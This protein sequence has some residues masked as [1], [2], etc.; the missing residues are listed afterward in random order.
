MVQYHLHLETW[1]HWIY[2][3]YWHEMIEILEIEYWYTYWNNHV[4]RDFHS[5]QLSQVSNWIWY[6]T[7]QLIVVQL[8]IQNNISMFI[9][10]EYFNYLIS[11]TYSEVNW[12]K[13]PIESGIGP[14]N[15]LEPSS[16]Y[17]IIYQYLL[18]FEIWT[19]KYVQL[20]QLSQVS[21]WIW[22]WTTQ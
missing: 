17:I 12:V 7:I 10:L 1:P 3:T 6:C 2:C 5:N 16:L 21:N 18:I 9:Q 14:F 11:N 20:N 19:H 22:Y 15:W 13:F 4:K 8:S